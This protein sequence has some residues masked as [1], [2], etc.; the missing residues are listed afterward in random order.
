MRKIKDLTG[1]KFTKLFVELFDQ[2]RNNKAY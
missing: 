1:L 2:I